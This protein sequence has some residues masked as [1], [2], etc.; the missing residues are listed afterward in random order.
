MLSESARMSSAAEAC[1][2]IPATIPTRRAVKVISLDSAGDR[3]I[4]TLLDEVPTADLVVMVA[5]AGADA[6]AAAIIGEACSRLRVMTTTL[7]VCAASVT[8]EALSKTLAQ[9]R[10]WSL[11]VVIASDDQ[12]V[13]DILKS[14]R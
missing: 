12:Y 2:R 5:S 4:A 9:V 7:V 1:F 10:P 3:E 13:E 8:D 6:H 11:M 14:F